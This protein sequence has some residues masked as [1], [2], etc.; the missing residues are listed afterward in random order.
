MIKF[1]RLVAFLIDMYP[2]TLLSILIWGVITIIAFGF[3]NFIDRFEP[4][5]PGYPL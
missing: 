4:L 3:D 5:V 2:L 1:K